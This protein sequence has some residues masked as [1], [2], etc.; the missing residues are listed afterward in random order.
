MSD[1][2]N[3]LLLK[4]KKQIWIMIYLMKQLD[5]IATPASIHTPKYLYIYSRGLQPGPAAGFG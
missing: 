4:I 3:A 2:D 1:N 5:K